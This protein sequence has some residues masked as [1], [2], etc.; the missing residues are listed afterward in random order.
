MKWDFTPEQVA[1]GEIEYTLEEFRADLMGEVKEN[2]S[3][4][5][6]DEV[7]SLFTLAYDVCYCSALRHDLQNLLDHCQQQGFGIDMQFLELIRDSNTD[8]T[9]MLKAIFAKKIAEFKE[10]GAENEE[11]LEK[12]KTYQQE[13]IAKEQGR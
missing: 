8:N 2:F 10:S 13:I 5:N 3:D 9:E 6:P 1:K 7:D 12:L 4:K 11:A